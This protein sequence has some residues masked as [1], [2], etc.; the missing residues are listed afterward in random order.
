MVESTIKYSK[1][2]SSDTASKMR[3]QTPFSLHG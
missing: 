3:R 1:S 2:G